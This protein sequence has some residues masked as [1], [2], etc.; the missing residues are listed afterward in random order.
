[1]TIRIDGGTVVGWSGTSHEL[2]AKG[3][4]LIDGD[5]ISYTGTD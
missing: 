1:M 2:I 4:V 3:S 5:T